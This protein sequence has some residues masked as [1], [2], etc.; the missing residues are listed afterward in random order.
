MNN[1]VGQRRGADGDFGTPEQEIPGTPVDGQLWESCMTINDHW[2]YAVYDNNYKSAA[3]LTRNLIGIA[4]NSGDYLL[5]VGPTD[6]GVIPQSSV[7]RLRG[8]GTWVSTNG[9][10]VFGAG[11]TGLVAKPSWGVVSRAGNRLYASVYSWSSV[12]HLTRLAPFTVTR[13]T[14]LATGAPVSVMASGDG[15]DLRPPGAA[16]D[17][18][19]SVIALD[20]VPRLGHPPATAPA[21]ARSTSPTRRS[22]VHLSP[23]SSQRS[24][25]TGGSPAL[26]P[27][28]SPP[29]TSPPAGPAPSNHHPHRRLP[30]LDPPPAHRKWRRSVSE[31]VLVEPEH[32]ATNR[33]ILAA[34]PRPAPERLRP[35][36]N[37]QRR[38][39]GQLRPHPSVHN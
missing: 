22:A 34:A 1:R 35:G 24:T 5:N 14:V 32:R 9:A 26:P 21:C 11:F 18:I 16:P 13:A 23:G 10:A 6:A 27:P 29:T 3:T 20:I 2:G 30:L 15:Y 4:S 7:D 12:L 28:R 19:A 39:V 8:M 37:L 33:A 25:S 38:L 17:P 31:T 36:N